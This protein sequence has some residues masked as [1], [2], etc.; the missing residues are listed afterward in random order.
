MRRKYVTALNRIWPTIHQQLK[1]SSPRR[2]AD[3]RRLSSLWLRQLI[4]VN[5]AS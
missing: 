2:R 4:S 5:V 1:A 3:L